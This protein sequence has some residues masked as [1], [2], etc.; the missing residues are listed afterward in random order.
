MQVRNSFLCSTTTPP[1]SVC[2]CPCPT[3]RSLAVHNASSFVIIADMTP[4]YLRSI[5]IFQLRAAYAFVE[6]LVVVRG[7]FLTELS[8]CGNGNDDLFLLTS[9]RVPRLR[10]RDGV[11]I[12]WTG[13]DFILPLRWPF[14][15]S[16]GCTLRRRLCHLVVDILEG[17]VEFL[18]MAWVWTLYCKFPPNFVLP[19]P[20]STNGHYTA[21]IP[22]SCS[23]FPFPIVE[24]S[25]FPARFSYHRPQ[26]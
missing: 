21:S 13:P 23:L 17:V 25:S 9:H 8:T 7:L 26:W 4:F 5:H 12:K 16:F 20:P 18:W 22:F 1:L 10:F 6:A 3:H 15:D 11:K 24:E 2:P 14:L 19:T